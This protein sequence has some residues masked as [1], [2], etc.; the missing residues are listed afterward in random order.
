MQINRNYHI[1]EATT[2][3]DGTRPALQHISIQRT[4]PVQHHINEDPYNGIALA[5]NGY[6]LAIVPVRLDP[7]DVTGLVN[8]NSFRE[9]IK[10]SAKVKWQRD[11]L[12]IVLKED[13]LDV[14]GYGFPRFESTNDKLLTFPNYSQ[15]IRRPSDTYDAPNL[16]INPAL[17]GKLAVAIGAPGGVCCNLI[18]PT[19]PIMVKPVDSQYHENPWQ[20]PYGVI[21]PMFATQPKRQEATVAA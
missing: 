4:D 11:D 16:G 1:W 7:E 21:M 3:K 18:S 9:A 8:W 20:P 5:A 12:Q 6:I 2:M 17:L 15:L 14:F 19:S 10:A 13:A